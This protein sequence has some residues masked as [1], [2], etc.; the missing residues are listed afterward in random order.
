VAG[1]AF[2]YRQAEPPSAGSK[3]SQ[4]LAETFERLEGVWVRRGH[5]VVEAAVRQ[6]TKAEVV[7]ALRAEVHAGSVLFIGDDE[8]DEDVFRA[9]E[10][11]DVT[12]RVGPGD[13]A[14]RYRV[15]GPPEVIELLDRLASLSPSPA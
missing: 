13:T 14:A 12:V 6:G 1:V 4:R 8:T 11:T 15:A 3:A 9:A 5:L 10:P 7:A 2:H